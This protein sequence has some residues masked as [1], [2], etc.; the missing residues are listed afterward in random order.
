MSRLRS[1]ALAGVVTVFALAPAGAS[2]VARAD[3]PAPGD[4]CTVLHATTRDANDRLMWC[5]PTMTGP[6]TLVWQYGGPS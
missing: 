5:N 6:H 2:G 4:E 1:L 3:P